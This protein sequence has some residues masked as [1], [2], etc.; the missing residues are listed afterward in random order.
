MNLQQPRRGPTANSTKPADIEGAL[1]TL[2]SDW[3]PNGRIVEEGRPVVVVL[4]MHRSG[5]ALLAN[6]LHYLGAD[7]ADET[8]VA[9]SKN[10]SG[11]WERPDIV[12]LHDDVLEAIRRPVD[13]PLHALPFPS[14]WWRDKKLKPLKVRLTE[15]VRRH[16]AETNGTWGFKD[17]RTCRL[18][19]L[20]SEV[21]E[22]LGLRPQYVWAIRTPGEAAASMAAKN[23]RLRPV[24]PQHAEVMWLAY[25]Y[26]ILRHLIGTQ[27]TIVD[28][29]E[30]FDDPLAVAD[31]L[32]RRLDLRGL[33]TERELAD[34]VHGIF[35]SEF[36]HF[37]E[38]SGDASSSIPV[39]QG[40]FKDLAELSRSEGAASEERL[41]RYIGLLEIIFHTLQPF[42]QSLS[43]VPALRK[44]VRLGE[45]RIMELTKRSEELAAGSDERRAESASLS[46]DLDAAR[47]SAEALASALSAEGTERIQS[48][49]GRTHEGL[50]SASRAGEMEDG[51]SPSNGSLMKEPA[52]NGAALALRTPDRKDITVPLPMRESEIGKLQAVAANLQA[53]LNEAMDRAGDV[54]GQLASRTQERDDLAARLNIREAAFAA[55]KA[56]G[57]KIRAEI[58][59]TTRRVDDLVAEL[60][61]S[62]RSFSE[63]Q[64]LLDALTGEKQVLSDT[65]AEVRAD[66][67]RAVALHTETQA[68]LKAALA[69]ERERAQRLETHIDAM[70]NEHAAALQQAQRQVAEV[71]ASLAKA[72]QER[73]YLSGRLAQAERSLDDASANLVQAATE[74]KDLLAK[75]KEVEANC[76]DLSSKLKEAETS[77]ND[78]SSKLSEAERSRKDALD[79]LQQIGRDK[80]ALAARLVKA[81]GDKVELKAKL[82]ATAQ[83]K[84]NLAS[85]LAKADHD[86]LDLA[87]KLQKAVEEKTSF[88]ARLVKADHDKV[89]ATARL[90]TATRERDALA[91]RLAK[92][93]RE[94]GELA[95]RLSGSEAER[96]ELQI[97]AEGY[98]ARIDARSK[99]PVMR[100]L[101]KPFQ[102]RRSLKGPPKGSLAS[103]RF[104]PAAGVEGFL[105]RF[106][107]SRIQ[108]WLY[109]RDRPS[110]ALRISFYDGER[111]LCTA[112]ADRTRSD[113]ARKSGASGRCGF[114]LP[115][116]QQLL[117]GKVHQVDVRIAGTATSLLSRPLSVRFDEPPKKS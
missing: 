24:S 21:F 96:R 100:R 47:V 79:K 38:G 101:F 71:E 12:A 90:G 56:D 45:A 93:D 40:L 69:T 92:A 54:V 18:L 10:P 110:E 74:K 41:G 39:A 55:L 5:T 48:S 94:K 112:V 85:R 23:P 53:Q 65:L 73:E 95:A 113:V 36:R 43:E 6:M 99:R 16:L 35:H 22:T 77:R 67:R 51:R 61:A 29:G 11:F 57:V 70:R 52:E 88:A 76:N 68:R 89:E 82:Q 105:D 17:P 78:L 32:L 25:N 80:E 15:A 108:G 33:E 50:V 97:A 7:M 87:A 13:S 115:M 4:G 86:K 49:A 8:D 26:D 30:W 64:T 72:G 114:D 37:V 14:G 60:E 103:I 75:L 91:E 98:L 107:P 83:D 1:A 59:I 28:Y 117:D 20:W 9:S 109:W 116:P 31:R 3:V 44:A 58:E 42:A 66:G 81:D 104:Q 106:G 19:P 63:V 34:C 84:N 2:D 102:N 46:A 62:K 111:F 27:P